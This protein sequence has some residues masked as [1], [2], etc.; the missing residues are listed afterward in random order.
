MNKQ[1]AHRGGWDGI[2]PAPKSKNC[3]R[4]MVLFSRAV[5]K[6]KG[7]GGCDRKSVKS[8]FS[9]ENFVWKFKICQKFLYPLVFGRSAHR[10]AASLLNY[11]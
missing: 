9:I 7:A 5:E 1:G 2:F 10:F 4:N 6:E 11:F 3:G 8:L